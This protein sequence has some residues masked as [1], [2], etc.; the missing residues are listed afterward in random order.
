MIRPLA[1]VLAMVAVVPVLGSPLIPSAWAQPSGSSSG[2]APAVGEARDNEGG[3]AAGEETHESFLWWMIRASGWIGVVIVAMS[4]YLIALVVWMAVHCRASVAIPRLLLREV[5]EMLDQRMYGEAYHR[6]AADD[7]LLAR[8]LSAGVRKLPSGLPLAQRAM[9]LANEDETMR[10]EHRTTYL[11]TVGTLGPMIG[12][13]GT[14]YGMILAFRVIA[15]EGATPQASELAQGISTALFATLEG[16]A[17]SIPAI[18]FYAM[19]RNRIARLS[20]EVGITA[21]PL[22]E[23][24]APGVRVMTNPGPVSVS[25]VVVTP[26]PTPTVATAPPPAPPTMPVHV[27]AP[28]S[29]P[30]PTAPDPGSDSGP[31][32]EPNPNPIPNPNPAAAHPHPFAVRATLAASSPVNPEERP[33]LPPAD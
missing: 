12:L 11:A 33:A 22:L 19:F 18:Y 28:V 21:E 27:P 24:F 26:T 20:L 5:E 2:P 9:E 4:F 13:V 8:V 15:K 32:P 14:V 10:M 25:P 7:S 1:I 30:R 17:L 3:Q 23:R 31:I 6:L 29:R 16:I